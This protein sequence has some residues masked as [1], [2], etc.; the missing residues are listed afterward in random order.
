MR[1]PPPTSSPAERVR[2]GRYVTARVRRHGAIPSMVSDL[3][4]TTA[5]VKS[6]GRALEDA[7]ERRRRNLVLMVALVV[8][9]VVVAI[10][11]Y[12]Y[13]DTLMDLR[14]LFVKE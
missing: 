11:V 13:R 14:Y 12:V 8:I 3:E 4:A 9:L 2:F 7:A 6:A 1:L 10:L 5:K